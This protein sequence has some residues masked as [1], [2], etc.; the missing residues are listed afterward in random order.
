MPEPRIDAAR[1]VRDLERLA[2]VG[3]RT[4]G[5]VTRLA[6]TAEDRK[7][8]DV[9]QE[10]L[11]ELG[12]APRTDRVGNLLGIR[13][14]TLTDAPVVLTGSHTDTVEAGGRFDGALGVMAGVAVLR[15]LDAA[16]V[17]TRHPVGVVSFVNEEGVRFM[18][19][20]MGSLF[21]RGDLSLADVHAAVG[22]DGAK[23]GDELARHGL[24][25]DDDFSAL[26]VSAFLE[27]HIEQGPV[28]DAAEEPVG[29]VTGVQGLR[30]LRVRIAGASN[31]AGT[32]PMR[33][34]R[35][36]GLVASRIVAGVRELADSM[37]P[38]RTTCGRLVLEPNVVNVI[39][40]SAHLTVDLRH[41]DAVGLS[42]AEAAVRALVAREAAT[43]TVHAA[44]ESLAHAPPVTFDSRIVSAVE[45]AAAALGLPCRRLLSG[46]G[47]DAQ[48][49]SRAWPSAMIFVRSRNGISHSPAEWSSPDDLVAGA[50]LLLRSVVELAG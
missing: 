8:R 46:A 36:A 20:M 43:E 16:G 18:P 27:L 4:D 30:W 40:A 45:Q 26:P 5:G 2:R 48:I 38:L 32:T 31:H 44:V 1:L 23:I 11:A 21:V 50:E 7:G 29:V 24:A 34:R 17:A 6:F 28:L 41:P 35:D 37:A 49:M 47:H 15:A 9:V 13:E 25:G 22:T 42:A 3:A 10:L 12:V 19:D 33:G 14:G 39:P